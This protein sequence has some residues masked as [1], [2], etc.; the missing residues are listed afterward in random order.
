VRFSFLR[1]S[2]VRFFP[3]H[4]TYLLEES[5]NRWSKISSASLRAWRGHTWRTGLIARA[6]Y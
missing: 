6:R 2:L 1:N 5:A 4:A 3:S